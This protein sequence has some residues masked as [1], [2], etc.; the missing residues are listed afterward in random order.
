M[1]FDGAD[2][3]YVANADDAPNFPNINDSIKCDVKRGNNT[4][5]PVF[6]FLTSDNGENAFYILSKSSSES[7]GSTFSNL[8]GSELRS[9]FK[10]LIRGNDSGSY[11][12]AMNWN[13][14][15]ILLISDARGIQFL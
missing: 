7:K 11:K 4:E 9:N 3:C 2:N 13:E 10:I 1:I 6:L 8:N 12:S 5:D 15:E 14:E